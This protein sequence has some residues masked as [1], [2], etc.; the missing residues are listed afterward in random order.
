M[1]E[2]PWPVA[3]ATGIGSMPGTDCADS[4]ATVFGELPEFPY[5]PELPDRGFGADMLGRSAALL[6]D[7]AVESMPTG[8]RVTSRSGREH[9]RA[10]DLRRWDLDA[11]EQAA[12]TA[13]NPSVIKTQ[14]AG[15]WSLAAGIELPRGHRVLT[16]HGAVRE[17]TQSLIEGVT[18]HVKELAAR[19]GATIVVQLDEPTLPDVLAGTLPTASGYGTVRSVPGPEAR[20]LLASMIDGCADATGAPVIVH[21]CARRPP[22]GL[23]HHAGAGAIAIDA[24][25]LDGAP[26]TTLDAIGEAWDGGVAFLLGLVPALEPAE[27]LD[28]RGVAEPALQLVDRIGFSRTILRD[29]AVPTPTCGLAGASNAWVRRALALTRDLGHAFAEPPESW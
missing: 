1:R 24:T 14:V 27:R 3:A 18:A 25:L 2:F 7:L 10:Q 15:P 6:V 9:R 4:V 13:G 5:Q 22:I 16:D 11:I 26:A 17:F 19:T 21:C 8:Y 28:L 20:A 12:H 23:M 29:Q